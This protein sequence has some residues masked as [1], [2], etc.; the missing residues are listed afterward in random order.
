MV[1]YTLSLSLSLSLVCL[2]LSVL[3]PPPLSLSL[4][5]ISQ[6]N[7]VF[8]YIVEQRYLHVLICN[9]NKVCFIMMKSHT[10]KMIAHAVLLS[11]PGTHY[12]SILLYFH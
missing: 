12:L 2:F 5:N 3:I 7:F 10:C 9:K 6:K 11:Y 1:V 4:S 8:M